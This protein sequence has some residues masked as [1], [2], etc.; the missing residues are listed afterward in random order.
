MEAAIRTAYFAITGKNLKDVEV[1]AVRGINEVKK[2]E[3]DI[4]GTKVRVAVVHGMA[5]AHD[6]LEEVRACKK[7]GKRAPYEFIEIMACRGGCVAGGGQPYG[8]TD[9]LRDE[10]MKGLYGDDEHCV[11]RCSHDNPSIKKLYKDYLGAPL[12]EKSEKLLH[13]NYK[14]V[15]VYK[16]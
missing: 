4:D 2:G 11:V 6:I 10:R 5:N 8:T 3:V 1:T 14:E 16:A 13:T 15:P 9:V 12:S 7:A